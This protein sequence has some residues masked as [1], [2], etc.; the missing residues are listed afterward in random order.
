MRAEMVV[1]MNS[2]AMLD[3]ALT[4]EE[5]NLLSV[6]YRN[7]IS[8]KR[9]SMRILTSIEQKEETRGKE[10]HVKLATEYCHKVEAE[11]EKICRDVIEIIDKNII[12]HSSGAESLVFYYKMKGD[13]YRYLAEF[14]MGTEKIEVSELSLKA[15]ETASK[16]AE[17]DLSPTNPCR[18]GLALNISVLYYEIMNSPEK[19]CQLAK[20][21]FDE[22]VSELDS[23]S[24][25]SYKDSTMIM[26]LLRDNLSLWNSDLADDPEDFKE[27]TGK[28]GDSAVQ[29]GTGNTGA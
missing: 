11:L 16:T 24:E 9:A 25:E 12:P 18:L 1:A 22:A 15:Y 7:L 21:A 29:E 13:Y 17:K 20:H 8:A 28:S 19:A 4:V 5:R 27:R 26:Q 3:E 6:G 14:K 2:V 10:N 23:L